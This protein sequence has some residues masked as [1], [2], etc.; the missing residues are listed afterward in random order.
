VDETAGKTTI[1]VA[2]PATTT[3]DAMIHQMRRLPLSLF[4]LRLPSRVRVPMLQLAGQC[5]GELEL[6][7]S[8]GIREHEAIL[9]DNCGR[10]VCQGFDNRAL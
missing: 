10:S 2:M 1:A 9:R 4:T 7:V 3:A 5:H 6:P 8:E